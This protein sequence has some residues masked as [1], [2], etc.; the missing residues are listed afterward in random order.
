MTWIF[1][2][3]LRRNSGARLED[4]LHLRFDSIPVTVPQPAAFSLQKLLVAPRRKGA[5]KR[6]KD[7]A[8]A[9][10]ILA[11]I[12]KKGEWASVQRVISRFPKSWKRV[13][14]KVLTDAGHAD[15][16]Q[17]LLG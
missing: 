6:A 1:S 11:L 7:I 14:V 15:L 8:T 5:E 16:G 2:Y 12:E 3:R 17:R 9:V 10:T 13:V 4:P